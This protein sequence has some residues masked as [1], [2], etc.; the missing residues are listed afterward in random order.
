MAFT[1]GGKAQRVLRLLLGVRNPRIA[2]A[3]ATHGFTE[4]DMKEGWDLLQA[5]GNTRLAGTLAPAAD[6]Q[7]IT[8][9]DT[10]E[11]QWFPIASAS[12][13]RHFPTVHERLFLNL[14]QTEGPEVAISVRTFIERHDAMS[15]AQSPYGTDGTQAAALLAQRGLTPAALAE[16]RALLAQLGRV[17]TPPTV[18]Y[19]VEE[20]KAE[21]VRAEEALWAWY[22]EWSQVARIAVKQR[23]LLKQLG[24]LSERVAAESDEDEDQEGE[25]AGATPVT[26]GPAGAASG[27]N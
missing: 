21:L 24:F 22:R 11:N 6:V 14:S 23:A 15:Q 2:T 20:Q 7:T 10:W 26:A 3:L 17:A 4:R 9:L 25:E 13:A 8:A 1:L 19:S 16:A 5:L 27:T 12:L 18:P